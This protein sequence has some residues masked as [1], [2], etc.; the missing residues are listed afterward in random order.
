MI[1]LCHVNAQHSTKTYNVT[2]K[3]DPP[4]F[5]TTLILHC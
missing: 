5:V 1:I 3:S 2:Q 4:Y